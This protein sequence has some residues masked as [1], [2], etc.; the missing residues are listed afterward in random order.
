[1]IGIIFLAAQAVALERLLLFDPIFSLSTPAILLFV[2]P[3]VLC[4]LVI[5]YNEH[6]VRSFVG[7]VQAQYHSSWLVI[8][9]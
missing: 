4:P 9:P 3:F 5:G 6:V 8:A 1:L 7:I 2:E